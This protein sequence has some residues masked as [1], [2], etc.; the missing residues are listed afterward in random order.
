MYGGEE[1]RR[2]PRL[3]LEA[4]VTVDTGRELLMGRTLE[5]SESGISATLPVEL[6]EGKEVELQLKLPDTTATTRAV[7]RNRNA[8]RHGFE[9]VQ[10]LHQ[11]V[12]SKDVDDC[13]G[14]AGTGFTVQPLCG[15]EGVAFATTRCRVCGGTGHTKP[16]A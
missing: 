3:K 8:L 11:L 2:H 13:E 1:R 9:F 14:C 16:G 5:V 6:R 10:P 15:Q 12:L 7:L 4:D